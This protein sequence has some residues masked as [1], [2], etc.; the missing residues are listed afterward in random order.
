[1]LPVVL[2]KRLIAKFN[3]QFHFVLLLDTEGLNPLELGTNDDPFKDN[4]LATF[5]VCLADVALINTVSIQN[6]K[7][8]E[9][10]ANA[11]HAV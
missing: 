4:E 2:E 10:L 9:L 3:N 8:Y 7:Q 11:A 6:K 5:G 1:M